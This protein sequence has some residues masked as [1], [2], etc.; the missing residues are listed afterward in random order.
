MTSSPWLPAC[1]A[2]AIHLP[3][4]IQSWGALLIAGAGDGIVRHASANLADFTG[5]AAHAAL[6]RNLAGLLPP[7]CLAPLTTGADTAVPALL[8]TLAGLP[9]ERDAA[10]V[11][12]HR[13]EDALVYEFEPIFT[14]PGRRNRSGWRRARQMMEALRAAATL[15]ALYS[16]VTNELRRA[17]GF[18]RA[19]LYRF[20]PDG[21]GEVMA[22]DRTPD[23]QSFAGLHYPASDVPRQARRLYLR[24]RVRVIA[25]VNAAAVALLAEP[26][27]PAADLSLAGLRAA[28]PIHLEYLRNMGVRATAAISL[29]IDGALWGMLVCHHRGPLLLPAH[30]RALCDLA[31]QVTA[32]MAATLMAAEA[33]A[34]KHANRARIDA[35]AVKLASQSPAGGGLADAL[36]RSGAGLLDL[37]AAQGAI[38]RLAG[39]TVSLGNAPSDD[40]ANALL[41]AVLHL[42]AADGVAAPDGGDLI[43]IDSL[44]S[45]LPAD[46]GAALGGSAAGALLLPL[47]HA[48]GDAVLWLRPE[49][50]RI[51]RWAGNPHH[52]AQID[53]AAGP[54]SPRRSFAVWQESI[55][56]RALP[57]QEA[58][59]AAARMLR[60]DLNGALVRQAEAD[61]ARLRHHDPLTGLPNRRLLRE[62]LDQWL[63]DSPTACLLVL[64]IDR[65]EAVNDTRG[66]AA[67]DTLLLQ[68]GARIAAV[69]EPGTTVAR[70]AGDEFAVL[71]PLLSQAMAQA[72]AARLRAVLGEPFEI[73]GLP[74]RVTASIGIAPASPAT[75]GLSAED[76]MTRAQLALHAAKQAG[77]DRIETFDSHL[78]QGVGRRME[79]EQ[80]L[81]AVLGGDQA[82]AGAFHLLYQ[83]CVALGCQPAA[84]QPAAHTK[85][86]PPMPPLR[87][88]EALLRWHHPLLGDIAPGEFIN[89]AEECGLIGAVGDWVLRAAIVQL[90]AWKDVAHGL[91]AQVWRVAVNVSP[92]QLRVA[93]FPRTVLALLAAHGLAPQAMTIEVT[94][95]VFADETAIAAIRTLRRAGL[96]VAVDDFGIGYSSLSYLRRMPADELKLDRSFLQRTDGAPEHEAFLAALVQLARSAGMSV[97]AEGVETEAHLAAISAAGCDAAQGWLFA[98]AMPAAQAATWIDAASPI[99]EP[100]RA[101]AQ[102]PFS[103]R[104][105]VETANDA[106]V[107]TTTKSEDPGPTIV[108]ANPAAGKLTGYAVGELLGR[109]PRMLHGP[110]TDLATV[111]KLILTLQSGQTGQARVLNY[112]AAGAAYWVDLQVAP[113]RNQHGEVTHFVAIERDASQDMRRLDELALAAERDPLTSVANRRGL[114]RFA[115]S[116]PL[117]SALPLCVAYIDLDKFKHINDTLG[118]DTGDAILLGVADLITQH[119]RRAD[120]VSRVGGDEFV[121]CMPSIQP[122]DAHAV[123]IRVQRAIC[124]TDIPTPR[125]PLRVRCSVGVAA[126]HGGAADI[127]GVIARA[128]SALYRAKAAGGA[129]T[130]LA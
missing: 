50:A 64:E 117:G 13:L 10:E 92:H 106:V 107:V 25:D 4:A 125:G 66:E 121:I 53:A 31:G 34:L 7:S 130:A 21:H 40:I 111:E 8:D 120:F 78:R 57:W 37:C 55:S 113:L 115:A 87:G 128:D 73:G 108:Y 51:V 129:Q 89:V 102:M 76:L 116:L 56:G 9:G 104:D 30:A 71:L 42:P 72:F 74:I 20:S 69:A 80:E 83:P 32:M 45:V 63:K 119:V 17:T 75:P 15:P 98:R 93:E 67:G 58:D 65:F 33:R 94:E 81:R 44:V 114:E 47:V 97:L 118:H 22:E 60:R 49:Q 11:S 52:P 123:A 99:V 85:G 24:Q 91:P 82:R 77:G 90:A 122:A 1:E 46:L 70:L 101:A 6:G 68:A 126:L 28:S 5:I 109:S 19:M 100:T 96:R 12:C 103:F 88:F 39:R 79:L 54:L 59:L 16:A 112:N 23:M 86:R 29:V 124:E 127:A 14:A 2:E 48:P 105:I 43:A 18:D 38:I 3:G 61:L 26:G 36:A 41:D 35:I 84:H 95:G 62:R 110:D 27:T